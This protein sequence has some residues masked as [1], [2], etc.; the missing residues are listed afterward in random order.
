MMQVEHAALLHLKNVV[1]KTLCNPGW[2]VI[3]P[4]LVDQEAVFGFESENSI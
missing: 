4:I 1:A 2:R 3:G